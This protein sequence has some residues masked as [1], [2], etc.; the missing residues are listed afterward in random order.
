MESKPDILIIGGGVIGVCS[1]YYLAS[2]GLQVALIEKDE[3]ASGCSYGNG[4]LIVPS[5]AIPLASPGALGQGLR[6][7]LDSISPFYIKPRLDMDLIRWLVGFVFAS[8]TQKML[9]SMP[10]LR[11]LLFASRA[12]FDELAQTAG[13]DFGFRGNGSLLVCLS[14]EA[15]EHEKQETR[16]FERFDIPFKVVDQDGAHDLEPALLPQVMGGIFYPR[17][18]CLDPARF[19]TGM[20]EKVEDLGVQVWTKTEAMGFETSRGRITNVHTTR[21]D[22]HP[23]QVVLATGSWSP[24]VA[25]SLRLRLPIQAAKG[26][27]VTLEN[28]AVAP[29]LP[30]L[31]S[32]ARVVATPLGDSLRIAGT[33]ELA[34]MDFSFNSRRV[35][36]IRR[37]SIAYLPGLDEAKVIEIWRGLR[38]C[39]PD[40]LPIISR[41][42]DFSNIIVAAGHAMLGMS[43]GPVTGKLV[44]QLIV[45]DQ[46]EVDLLPLKME[47]F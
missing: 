1:A 46:T 3:I 22:F 8:R 37:S 9:Q 14:K 25:H 21:G 16:L 34:G 30:L 35:D 31:F 40:G 7:M 42:S 39:T 6:W 4:G 20:A 11:D 29:K 45:G 13:F 5:H 17:D 32:E 33:L 44:A 24:D 27:S 19:V 10:V 23:K 12:L 36:A 47:R 18:G 28:P 43:L 26:Y 15:L 2:S 38:P 41:S